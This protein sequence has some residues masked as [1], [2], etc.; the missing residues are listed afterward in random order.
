M[1]LDPNKAPSKRQTQISLEILAIA[2]DF[3]QRESSGASLIIVTRAEVSADMKHG[4]IFITVLPE[5]KEEAAI[6]FAKRMRSELR[7]YVMK[8]LPIKVNPFF[9]VEIDYGEKNR[10]HVDELLRKDKLESE[11]LNKPEND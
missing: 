4:T 3:F 11:K 10:L 7:H 1:I 8:R 2:Q 5:S 9:E 6:N